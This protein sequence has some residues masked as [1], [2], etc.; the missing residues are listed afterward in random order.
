VHLKRLPLDRIFAGGVLERVPA[1]WGIPA[2]VQG[3]V[4]Y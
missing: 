3:R 4:P 2:A 1:G